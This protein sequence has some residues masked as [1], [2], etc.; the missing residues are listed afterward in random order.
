M[1]LAPEG[2]YLGSNKRSEIF[3]PRRGGIKKVRDT[4]YEVRGTKYEMINV[5]YAHFLL[6]I[7]INSQ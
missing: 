7:F 6:T 4:K 2:R 5:Y 1:V 3:E